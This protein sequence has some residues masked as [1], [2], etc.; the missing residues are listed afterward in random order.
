M[1][2]CG[3]FPSGFVRNFWAIADSRTGTP[4]TP[5][6][7]CDT[8][9][10]PE[11]ALAVSGVSWTLFRIPDLSVHGSETA[12][13]E[14]QGPIFQCMGPKRRF[15]NK[16][17][18][19]CLNNCWSDFGHLVSFW[20]FCLCVSFFLRSFCGLGRIQEWDKRTRA[21]FLKLKW[22]R[23]F[24]FPVAKKDRQLF[25]IDLNEFYVEGSGLLLLFLFPFLEGSGWRGAPAHLSL[26]FLVYIGLCFC[27]VLVFVCFS[28]GEGGGAVL[29]GLGWGEGAKGPTSSNP[30]FFLFC[31]MF[32]W[33]SLFG[34]LCSKEK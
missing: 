31:F 34:A 18:R 14:K 29:E 21:K 32:F 3:S 1:K 9:G 12:I 20:C 28:L 5:K 23:R 11:N 15:W 13:L 4:E 19:P 33:L 16:Q 26:P 25:K 7:K 2:T 24:I 6:C 8:C 10:T 27:V 30:Q 22:D 17:G